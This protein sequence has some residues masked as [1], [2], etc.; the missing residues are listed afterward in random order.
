MCNQLSV[1][2]RSEKWPS[3]PSNGNPAGLRL[4]VWPLT[5]MTAFFMLEPETISGES[6]RKM[7]AA[8]SLP[9]VVTSISKGSLTIQSTNSCTAEFQ[10]TYIASTRR[11]ARRRLSQ[12]PETSQLTRLVFLRTPACSMAEREITFGRLKPVREIV[13]SSPEPETMTSMDS[14]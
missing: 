10:T 9:E 11:M 8:L 1:A 4:K 5:G 3:N 12:A 2:N 14:L 6:T 7:E 13:R